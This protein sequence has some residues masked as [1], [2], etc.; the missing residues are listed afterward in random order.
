M[1]VGVT[2]R[3]VGVAV[4][5]GAGVGVTVGATAATVGVAMLEGVD[6]DQVDEEAQDG[7]DE[8]AFVFYLAREKK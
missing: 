8:K 4:V 5:G 7:D 6:A 1:V 2:V 3:I